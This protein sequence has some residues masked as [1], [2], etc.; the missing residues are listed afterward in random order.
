MSRVKNSW[1]KSK[2]RTH[3]PKSR[4]AHSRLPRWRET[5]K[6]SRGASRLRSRDTQCGVDTERNRT[7]T[8]SKELFLQ[9]RAAPDVQVKKYSRRGW[10]AAAGGK[11]RKGGRR[12]G[13]RAGPHLLSRAAR[14]AGGGG[15][16]PTLARPPRGAG[17]AAAAPRRSP[18]RGPPPPPL[19][20]ALPAP[21]PHVWVTSKFREKAAWW[22][23]ERRRDS[24]AQRPPPGRAGEGRGGGGRSADTAGSFS[25]GE[26]GPRRRREPG[27]PRPKSYWKIHFYKANAFP[28]LFS[29]SRGV[30]CG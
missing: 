27:A 28:E 20:L 5:R 19:P 10:R 1:C 22:L 12:P 4:K 14:P 6:P 21:S 30:S 8:P 13:S 18:A 7:T 25:S 16:A 26:A 17:H 29:A 15:P 23:P 24:A 9:P 11:A 2:C 3:A